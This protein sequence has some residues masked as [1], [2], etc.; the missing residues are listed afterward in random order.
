MQT[1]NKSWL[2]ELDRFLAN[3]CPVYLNII[4]CGDFNFPKVCWESPEMTA[5]I[6]E[7]KFV[8]ILGDHF[9]TRINNVPTRGDHI[10][11]L[12]ITSAPDLIQNLS[13]RTPS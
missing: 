3:M 8:E 1:V 7:V 13:Y 6:D 5:G 4:V 10:L 12:V 2:E 9:L 11:D